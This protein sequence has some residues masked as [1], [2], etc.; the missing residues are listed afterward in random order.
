MKTNAATPEMLHFYAQPGPMTGVEKH[1]DRLN[2]LPRDIQGLVH[3]VQGLLIHV[4]WAERYGVTLPEA[5]QNEVEIRAAEAMLDHA[6][7]LDDRPLTEARPLK[8]RLVGNCRD[9]TT[10]LCA[11]LRHH[12]MP[13]RA[14]CGF[15]TYFLPDHYEDH[16]ICEV[17]RPDAGRWVQVDAQL[18]AFQRE[19]LEIDF[20]PLDLP[21]GVFWPG[22]RAWLACRAGEADAET[23]GI[24]D[25]HGMGFIRG[26]V[27][28]DFLALNKVELLPW[29]GRGIMALQEEALTE[30]DLAWLDDVATLTLADY[31]GFEK[32]RARFER[33]PR[34]APLK[35]WAPGD[36][37]PLAVDV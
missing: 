29:D 34:I 35:R 3:V 28:R 8:K 24:F 23:F 20:D 10:L 12:G 22:G 14:R 6:L 13:A 4:F 11:L 2:A 15:A 1:A 16:W 31:A 17:W 9:F 27:L 7:T 30:D 18:D 21:P 32:I 5:R 36:E 25:M 19:A 33:D 37:T 26:N